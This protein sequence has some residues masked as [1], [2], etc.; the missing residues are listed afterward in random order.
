MEC[1][2]IIIPVYNCERTI[3]RCIASVQKQTL[4]ELEILCIDDGSIDHS[5]DIILE[6]MKSDS[7]IR[8]FSKENGGAGSARN[9]G[10]NM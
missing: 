6:M 5:A 3:E 7:R 10:Q 9:K 2:T 4:K 1:I 8:L